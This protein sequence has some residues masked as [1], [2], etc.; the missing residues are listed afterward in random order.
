M[1]KDYRFAQ[2]ARAQEMLE[3]FVYALDTAKALENDWTSNAEELLDILW[4]E[5]SW[6]E[7]FGQA[8]PGLKDSFF[9]Q[10]AENLRF[11]LEGIRGA[12]GGEEIPQ[13]VCW[14]LPCFLLE[15]RE[16]LYF[17]AYV[18]PFPERWADYY[19]EEFAAHHSNMPVERGIS[20]C[21]VSIFVPAKDNLE[22]T[23]RCV[24]SILRETDS[25][26]I[27]YELI[28]INHGSQ[29]GTQSYFESIPGAKLLHFKENVHMMMFSAALRVCEGRYMAFV[30]NDTVVT[31]DWLTLLHRCIQSGPNI[32]SAT[33]IT[34]NTSNFQSIAPAY[35]D[36]E[37]MARFAAGYNRHDPAQWEQRSRVLPVIALYDV[38]KV[39]TIGFGDR[40]F[41]TMEFWDD[42]F[43]LR[44]RRAG[45]QQ[46]LCRN[47]FCHHYGSVTGK[48]AQVKD[49]TL[50]KGRALFI[51]KHGADPWENGAYY[52]YPLC[53]RLQGLPLPPDGQAEVLGIDAGFGDTLLQIGNILRKGGR[54]TL[55]D[56]ITA[57]K[58]YAN[59][60]RSISRSFYLA[61]HERAMLAGLDREF[62]GRSYDY[63]YISRP[64]ER[65]T[66]PQAL[67][68]GLSDKLKPGGWLMFYLSNALDIINVQWF[69][70]L[71][72]PPGRECLN[73]LNPDRIEGNLKQWLE[74]VI[75]ERKLGGASAVLLSQLAKQVNAASAPMEVIMQRLDTL[76]F[77][78]YA[79]KKLLPRDE[80][81]YSP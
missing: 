7:A 18:Y 23:R 34:P 22:Y 27:S 13:A 4:E 61:E 29:D 55:I 62:S 75:V 32:I 48:K 14:Q 50:Q 8:L 37:E 66:D 74:P 77:Y 40:Y 69:T 2:D 59:D 20:K 21:E 58:Q 79:R 52:D 3:R 35:G 33:P 81:A 57:E 44:A 47:I 67:L 64:L 17:G 26:A 11:T 39:N 30:S 16:E 51:A 65:Y 9:A 42:D 28:L 19:Q 56:S 54:E 5:L 43:S 12:L 24:E 78:Y 60:L 36:L 70:W 68:K 49:N 38:Q 45:Y 76:G 71:A 15:L 41:R 10:Q 31:K 72:F 1:I 46:I 80:N 25:A 63:I 73:Y 53:A 6:L